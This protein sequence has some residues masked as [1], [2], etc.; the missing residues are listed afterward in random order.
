MK[1]HRQNRVRGRRPNIYFA[2][3]ADKTT[4]QDSLGRAL[5]VTTPS[6]S[7]SASLAAHDSDKKI[8][9]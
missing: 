4:K 6:L 1:T 8:E 2:Q 5:L 9:T 3:S 7:L